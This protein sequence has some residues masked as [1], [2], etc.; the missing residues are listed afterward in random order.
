MPGELDV[1]LWIMYWFSALDC[2]GDI[3]SY[4]T[5][6]KKAFT[7]KSSDTESVFFRLSR[8]RGQRRTKEGENYGTKEER[9]TPSGKTASES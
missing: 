6:K 7:Y 1:V 5:W 8:F 4:L 3:S 2:F 9:K